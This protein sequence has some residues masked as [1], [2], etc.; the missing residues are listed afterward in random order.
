MT[1]ATSINL[2]LVV[3]SGTLVVVVGFALRVAMIYGDF[4]AR[5][6]RVEK[7]LF[8]GDFVSKQEIAVRVED[9]HDDHNEF[10]R[11]IEA[12]EARERK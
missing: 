12:I 6:M 4:K 3:S 7:A 1:E 9:A 8:N 2:N 11:R 10:R 5:L